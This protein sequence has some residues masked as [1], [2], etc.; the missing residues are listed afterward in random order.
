MAATLLACVGAALIAGAP[1]WVTRVAL[2]KAAPTVFGTAQDAQVLRKTTEDVTATTVAQRRGS[3]QEPFAGA[4]RPLPARLDVAT[5]TDQL[6]RERFL[7]EQTCGG[8]PRLRRASDL[9][10]E[11]ASDR[12]TSADLGSR[13]GLTRCDGGMWTPEDLPHSSQ[14]RST[15]GNRTLDDRQHGVR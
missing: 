9:E 12:N 13:S 4:I 3:S 7:V 10:G 5:A 14:E 15:V 11:R 1:D 2:A 6:D 8:A